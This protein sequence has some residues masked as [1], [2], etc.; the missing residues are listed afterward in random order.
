L[1]Q[2]GDRCLGEQMPDKL[3]A[4]LVQ[5]LG[6]NSGKLSKRF[7]DKEFVKLTD[8]EVQILEETYRNLFVDSIHPNF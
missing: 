4:L 5:I 2:L 3:L 7:R 6:Q 8:P 1:Y